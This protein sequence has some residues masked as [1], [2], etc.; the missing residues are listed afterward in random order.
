MQSPKINEANN[1]RITGVSLKN[2]KKYDYVIIGTD[3]SDL[4][5]SLILKN[6]KKIFDSRGVFSKN[7]SK[8][9]ILV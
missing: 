7:K 6:A 5:K 4:K 8:K 2:L 9:V 3:H 1:K